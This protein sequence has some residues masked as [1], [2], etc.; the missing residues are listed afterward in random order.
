MQTLLLA[1]NGKRIIGTLEKVPAVAHFAEV[2]R[3]ADG[4]F[5]FDYSGENKVDWDCQRTECD[6]NGEDLF[7]DD[8]GL[9]WPR[10][11]LTL[12]EL[13]APHEDADLCNALAP[14]G[15]GLLDGGCRALAI[16]AERVF[17]GVL[18]RI[19]WEP[20]GGG[21]HEGVADHFYVLLPDGR[22]FDGNGFHAAEW[23]VCDAWRKER[24]T[25]LLVWTGVEGSPTIND[26]ET[27]S[28]PDSLPALERALRAWNARQHSD[29]AAE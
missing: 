15:V 20:E 10:S 18:R 8:S 26:D 4:S 2:R 29:L 19:V 7:V 12:V 17:G 23:K 21:D 11:Q 28:Y 24:P 27:P 1:P 9:P 16:A 22:C 3:S 6:E 5:E 25:G 13:P 14:F